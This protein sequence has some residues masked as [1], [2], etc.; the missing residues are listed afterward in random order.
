M[1]NRNTAYKAIFP[2]LT[3]ADLTWCWGWFR[4]ARIHKQ[5]TNT[6]ATAEASAYACVQHRAVSSC[7]YLALLSTTGKFENSS[8]EISKQ[9]IYSYNI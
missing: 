3:A 4:Q 6:V 1:G 7:P 8:V 5:H 2:S 9:I